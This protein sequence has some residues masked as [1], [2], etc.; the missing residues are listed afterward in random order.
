MDRWTL[1]S[2]HQLN[3]L[4]VLRL[5]GV[6]NNYYR[7]NRILEVVLST[8]SSMHE[9]D[10]DVAAPLDFDFRCFFLN[11]PRSQMYRRIDERVEQMMADGLMQV[12]HNNDNLN[13][14]P[15]PPKP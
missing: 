1:R 9:L 10:L 8:G 15:L 3:T 13:P 6:P 5:R 2:A 7:L 4:Y 12:Q 14:K 11:R